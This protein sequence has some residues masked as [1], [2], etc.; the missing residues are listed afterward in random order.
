MIYSILIRLS[1]LNYKHLHTK[2]RHYGSI[3]LKNYLLFA[4]F[5]FKTVS[6]NYL[7]N[8][9]LRDSMSN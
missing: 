3:S 6:S 7:P 2:S 8:Y 1:G 5:V 4:F 9:A